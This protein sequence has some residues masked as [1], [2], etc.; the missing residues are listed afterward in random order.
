MPTAEMERGGLLTQGRLGLTVRPGH[1]HVYSR[2]S[3]RTQQHSQT[4]HVPCGSPRQR[5]AGWNGTQ[6]WEPWGN[7]EVLVWTT[8]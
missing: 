3:S 2:A 7:S 1:G 8:P 6:H 5:S 4:G